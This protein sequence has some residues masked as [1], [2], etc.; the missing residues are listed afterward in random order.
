MTNLEKFIET[1]GVYANDVKLE[2]CDGF[3]CRG[4]GNKCI[5]CERYHFWEQ[6]YIEPKEKDNK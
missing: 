5:D 1:F 4:R 3:Y 2:D 6:E